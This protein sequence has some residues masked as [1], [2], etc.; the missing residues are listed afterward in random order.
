MRYC[1]CPESF[2]ETRGLGFSASDWMRLMIFRRSF[3]G[4]ASSSFAAD[5]L[6]VI[7]Y[8]A[9]FSELLQNIL[10]R[11][12]WLFFALLESRQVNGILR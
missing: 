11:Q 12:A 6:I 3:F 9:I 8:F 10:K 4:R 5:F 2:C 1:S 7:L